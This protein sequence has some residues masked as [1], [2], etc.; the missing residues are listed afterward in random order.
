MTH[1]YRAADINFQSAL[2]FQVMKDFVNYG[3]AWYAIS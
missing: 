1:A 2:F 3:R